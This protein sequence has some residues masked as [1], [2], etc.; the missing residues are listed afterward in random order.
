MRVTL[1]I[2]RYDPER[3]EKPH[4]VDYEVEVDETDRLLDALNEIKWHVDGSLTYRRSCAHGIC[5]SDGMLINGQNRLACKCLIRELVS[6]GDRRITVEPMRGYR[7]IKDLVIDLEPFFESYRAM[8]PYLINDQP[9]PVRERLQSPEQR[10]RY[11]DTTKC[12]LCAIC[13]TACPPFWANPSFVGPAAIVNAHR[14]IYDSRDEGSEERLEVLNEK[15]GV[16]RCRTVFNCTDACP[17]GI[18]ITD[19]IEQIKRELL[20][21]RI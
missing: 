19:A 14:F 21:R 18:K 9:P 10:E 15:T 7:V 4:F 17:R 11:D 5:G 12:I 1:N 3:D 2:L 20:F 16:W 6:S 8:L 13:T